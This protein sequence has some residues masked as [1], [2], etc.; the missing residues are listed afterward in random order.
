MDELNKKRPDSFKDYPKGAR[1]N[2]KRAIEWAEKNGWGSCG[3]GVGKQR[4]HQ[5]AKGEGLSW[6][7]VKR[8]AAFR[9][10]QKNKDTPYSEGCGGLMWDAWGG[11]AGVRWAEARV[12]E[13]S[14]KKNLL[15]EALDNVIN[16]FSKKV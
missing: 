7:T 15:I 12:K 5:L 8:M 14:D 16:M 1:N 11:D 13:Y 3:T 4:A 2:A 9:R 10:H 6:E